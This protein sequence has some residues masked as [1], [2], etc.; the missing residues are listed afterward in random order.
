MSTLVRNLT[1]LSIIALMVF[2]LSNCKNDEKVASVAEKPMTADD[3]VG[4]WTIVEAYLLFLPLMNSVIISS[5]IPANT[6]IPSMAG[7]SKSKTA[8]ELRM[9]SSN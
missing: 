1:S 5:G 7:E 6:P 9:M 8:A 3:L 4:E 2:C